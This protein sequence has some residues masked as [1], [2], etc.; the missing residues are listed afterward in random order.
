[1]TAPYRR[2]LTEALYE[3]DASNALGINGMSWDELID[4]L[5]PAVSRLAR[6]RAA[7]ELR[8]IAATSDLMD[9]LRGDDLLARANELDLQ[10]EDVTG[11]RAG[12]CGDRAPSTVPGATP[13]F[14]ELLVGHAGWHGADGGGH[15]SQTAD[16]EIP[17]WHQCSSS[18]DG[19]RCSLWGGHT[20][21]HQSGDSRWVAP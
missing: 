11:D 10:E 17:G 7:H 4:W 20:N 21:A 1:M 15:W 12:R 6:Q 18:N 8:V 3:A 5:M 2:L 14:C 16:A 19:T 9:H 13:V